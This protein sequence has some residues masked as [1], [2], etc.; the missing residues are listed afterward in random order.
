MQKELD[1]YFK[2]LSEAGEG[3]NRALRV[4]QKPG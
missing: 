3:H 1:R 2:K 4:F